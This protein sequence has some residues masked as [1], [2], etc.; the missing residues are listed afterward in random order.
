MAGMSYSV[1]ARGPEAGVRGRRDHTGLIYCT[2]VILV[3]S[4][5][6]N[7]FISRYHSDVE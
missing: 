1:I 4:M 3:V 7:D 6:S 2:G 5:R